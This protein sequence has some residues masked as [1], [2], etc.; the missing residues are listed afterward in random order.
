MEFSKTQSQPE[1]DK[2]LFLEETKVA[3]SMKNT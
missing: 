3:D 2:Q 1:I